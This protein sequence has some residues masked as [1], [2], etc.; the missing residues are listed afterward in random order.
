MPIMLFVMWMVF[1][2]RITWDVIVTGAIISALLTWFLRRFTSWG[3]QKDLLYVKKSGQILGFLLRLVLEVL[4]A[5]VHVIALVLSADPKIQPQIV[6]RRTKAKTAAGK[7]ALANSITLTPGTITIDVGD[8]W[9]CVHAID[10]S[11]A[12]GLEDSWSERKIERLE[13]G[14]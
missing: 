11:S 3:L 12:A 5:N 7:V 6:Y 10:D 13:E 8:D 2:G 9:I 1:N 4:K 14:L